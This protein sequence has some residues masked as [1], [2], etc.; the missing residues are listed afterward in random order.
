MWL[1]LQSSPV[2]HLP[3]PKQ[4]LAAHGVNGRESDEATTAL[5]AGGGFWPRSARIE[6]IANKRRRNGVAGLQKPMLVLAVHKK[7]RSSAYTPEPKED[8][9]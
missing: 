5:M 3:H 1:N 9:V 2:R 8:H 6:P 7:Q 4:R